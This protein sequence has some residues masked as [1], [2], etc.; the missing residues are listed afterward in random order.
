M[1]TKAFHGGAFFD[2]IGR[3]FQTMERAAEVISADV[4]DAWFVPSPGVLQK[5]GEHLAFALKTSPPTQAEGLVQTICEV[6]GLAANQIL[7]GGGSSDL[8]FILLP[9]LLRTTDCVA[10]LDPMYGEYAHILTQVKPVSLRRFFLEKESGFAVET[11]KCA[12]FLA[13]E[14]PS[15]F[16]V[17]NPNNPTGSHWPKE[18]ILLLVKR[19]RETVF[20]IDEAY[21]E[22]VGK[23]CSLELEVARHPNLIIVK[24]MSKAY[25]LSGARVAYAVC[26]PALRERVGRLIPPWPVSL[27]GQM[28]GVEA[29]RD[30]P[31][32]A[33]KYAET[34][35]IKEQMVAQLESAKGACDHSLQTHRHWRVYNSCANWVLLEL[36]QM[37]AG[38][39]VEALRKE[40]VFVRHCGSMSE[41]FRDDFIR[42]AV[43]D[44]ATAARIVKDIARCCSALCEVGPLR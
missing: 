9:E 2:S 42:V 39:L 13:R 27:L 33:A 19:F 8:L 40:Q 35:Q 4:L 17:V 14:K 36:K 1:S 18:E 31:Y 10:I 25:A 16:C 30:E 5:I 23:S 38:G 34:R 28:A 29:L 7:V 3:D 41:Q 20:V 24:S 44:G 37:S 12:D 11:S 26:T 22:Y 21:I 15:M 6:R 43:K 32:Y